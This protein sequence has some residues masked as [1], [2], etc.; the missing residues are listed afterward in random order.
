MSE[1]LNIMFSWR[2]C[3][4]R[5]LLC[6]SALSVL[7][8]FV[9]ELK[10][11]N[12][13]DEIYLSIDA[14]AKSPGVASLYQDVGGSFSE[15]LVV[16]SEYGAGERKM[17]RFKL[18]G[19]CCRALRFDPVQSG[20]QR[21]VIYSARIV[22][23]TGAAISWLPL[24][25]LVSANDVKKDVEGNDSPVVFTSP[26]GAA[27]PIISINDFNLTDAARGHHPSLVD[28]LIR[29]FA[30]FGLYL[31]AYSCFRLAKRFDA[32]LLG[33]GCLLLLG[34]FAFV[35]R[36]P[37]PV[38]TNV[39]YAE[40]GIWSGMLLGKNFFEVLWSARPDY[41][42]LI[43]LI[44]L[45]FSLIVSRLIGGL[46]IS[47]L[48]RVV[49]AIS[50]LFFSLYAFVVW[51]GLRDWLS[52]TGRMFCWLSFIFLY[53]GGGANEVFGRGA[54]A[55]LLL[56]VVHGALIAWRMR[57]GRQVVVSLI[58]VAQVVFAFS[59]P[60]SVLMG[61]ACWMYSYFWKRGESSLPGLGR[62]LDLLH[63]GV[64][65]ALS[66]C[67]VYRYK[68]A[69]DFSTLSG[70]LFIAKNIF[71][72][73]VAR[74]LLFPWVSL[75]YSKINDAVSLVLLLV[76]SGLACRA[77][78][79]QRFNKSAV[80]F[81]FG[82]LVLLLGYS[83]AIVILRPGL[84]SWIGGYGSIYP[85]RYFMAQNFFAIVFAVWCIENSFQASSGSGLKRIN[86]GILLFIP[87]VLT[88]PQVFE[89]SEPKMR[90]AERG[91][92]FGVDVRNVYVA[93]KRRDSYEVPVMP[94]GFFIK[95][96]SAYMAA[97]SKDS[98]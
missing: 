84:T 61:G 71:E 47:I 72:V 18:R 11:E 94:K 31:F 40:D 22:D 16:N 43:N 56:P 51:R 8:L 14:E 25:A 41:F 85:E 65:V 32:E 27:D 37:D 92:D 53:V 73:F 63:L 12:P 75:V 13:S 62:K 50:F 19:D 82:V 91:R 54:N 66:L 93:E 83:A 95:V 76:G 23:S 81:G 68:M 77:F 10:G 3:S 64:V 97:T 2:F 49:A 24:S 28:I 4:W 45:K 29:F 87:V 69:G 89:V 44:I 80:W 33:S 30:V 17:L 5:V 9:F 1:G 20:A 42:V 70:E 35:V 58:D 79:V 88:W 15:A 21:M 78:W 55:A 38:I 98:R 39:L 90:F 26:E 96:P 36:N 34:V 6:V 7:S 57:E 74:S 46:D 59:N 48:P 60:I 86:W 67:L 52:P